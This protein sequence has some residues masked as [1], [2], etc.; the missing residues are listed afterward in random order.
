VPLSKNFISPGDSAHLSVSYPKPSSEP[1][2]TLVLIFTVELL[3]A[4]RK[5]NLI[6]LAALAAKMALLDNLLL[7]QA[8]DS[9]PSSFSRNDM[10]IQLPS[11]HELP[12]GYAGVYTNATTGSA[13]R[14]FSL[15]LKSHLI[16]PDFIEFGNGGLDNDPL[17]L[18]TR[19]RGYCATNVVGFGF[20]IT[21]NV[22]TQGGPSN[23][24]SNFPITPETVTLNQQLIANNS[25]NP[26]PPV[27]AVHTEFLEANSP[28]PDSGIKFSVDT[29]RIMT[30]YAQV[31]T[32]DSADL[33]ACT[34]S[35]FVR[36]CHLQPAVVQYP[37]Q[38]TNFSNNKQ[39]RLGIQ[40]T[41]Y[42][43]DAALDDPIDGLKDGQIQTIKVLDQAYKT[44][45][46]QYRSNILAIVN[47]AQS[48]FTS[49]VSLS[50]APDVGYSIASD[51]RAASPM[52]QWW[53]QTNSR[54]DS[55][56][57]EPSQKCELR[58]V[59]PMHFMI[60][61]LNTLMLRASIHASKNLDP[62][63][64]DLF[65]PSSIQ[66]NL[67]GEQF[68]DTIEYK[69]HYGFMYA[70]LA[71]MMACILCVLPSYVSPA[72][73]NNTKNST[74]TPTSGVSGSWAGRSP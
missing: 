59:N 69:S 1:Y 28:D 50:Y 8:A 40:I 63:A 51:G 52:S 12:R 48:L 62:S 53:V 18:D 71:L 38:F 33:T 45:N 10:S 61:Q 19:C 17:G 70:A 25:D 42:T 65:L 58:V 35:L 67:N 14:P 26:L 32:N 15:D 2:R 13:S 43:E 5:F 3:T 41:D 29:I 4:G 54:T 11:V 66:D 72:D 24:S 9:V 57:W 44:D 6:A 74:L 27:L 31:L 49:L 60:G 55:G 56:L 46:I 68:L 22:H 16:S 23:I 36:T 37:I 20:N 30:T 64:T 21:C 39:A 34:G 7:Q 73:H 47:V